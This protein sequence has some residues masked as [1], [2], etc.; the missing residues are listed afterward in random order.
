MTLDDLFNLALRYVRLNYIVSRMNVKLHKFP[1][2]V[3]NHITEC[4][5]D[6]LGVSDEY[7]SIIEGKDSAKIEEVYEVFATELREVNRVLFSKIYNLD[8]E[9]RK[10]LYDRLLEERKTFLDGAMQ[11]KGYYDKIISQIKELE[12]S[13]DREKLQSLYE[14]PNIFRS[15]Y[16]ELLAMSDY[17]SNLLNYMAPLVYQKPLK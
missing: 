13:N 11:Y 7:A 6:S 2:D 15:R 16:Y 10:V 8:L 9:D 12:G 14:F 5:Y 17:F 1:S 3:V 4:D